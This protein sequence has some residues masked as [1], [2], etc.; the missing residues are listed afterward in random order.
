MTAIT[1]VLAVGVDP[2]VTT[3]DVEL[4]RRQVIEAIPDTGE[5]TG[6]EKAIEEGILKVK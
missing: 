4:D 2:K 6:P 1:M 5:H 3:S